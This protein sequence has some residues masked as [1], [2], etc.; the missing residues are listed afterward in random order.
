MFLNTMA[1][2]FGGIHQF[3][4]RKGSHRY[5]QLLGFGNGG[6]LL[7]AL[8]QPCLPSLK[9]PLLLLL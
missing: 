9:F 8:F 7:L 5:N 1:V 6:I 3:D 2:Q 4:G